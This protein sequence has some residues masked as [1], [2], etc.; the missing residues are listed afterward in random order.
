MDASI[1][2]AIC[3]LVRGEQEFCFRRQIP[4][5]SNISTKVGK[6]I[7]YFP[8]VPG[9]GKIWLGIRTGNANFSNLHH[10]IGYK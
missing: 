9:N 4:Q 6:A 1:A 5:Y 3:A 7:F 2:G 8:P 10:I